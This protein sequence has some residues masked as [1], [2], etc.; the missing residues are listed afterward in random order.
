M[1][2][3]ARILADTR[4]SVRD[5]GWTGFYTPMPG[6]PANYGYSVGFTQTYG[7]PEAIVTGLDLHTT[8]AILAELADRLAA[9]ERP[10][11]HAAIDLGL[12][13]PVVLRPVTRATTRRLL[14]RATAF[15]AG[16]A[17]DA[18]QVVWP[19]PGGRFPWEA[20]HRAAGSYQPLLFEDA[21]PD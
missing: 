1:D 4:R 20:G 8:N 12:T 2:I 14:L 5:R 16:A 10:A 17:Y 6:R 21:P 11:F 19:D 9:G 18:V 15:Y 3:P 7:F 13:L